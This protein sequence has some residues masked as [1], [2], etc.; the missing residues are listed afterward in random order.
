VEADAVWAG[1]GHLL[2]SASFVFL[3]SPFDAEETDSAVVLPCWL[4]R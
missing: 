3:S 4:W 2:R 1:P